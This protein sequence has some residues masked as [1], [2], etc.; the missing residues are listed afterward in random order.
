M[1]KK[2]FL[3]ES[4]RMMKAC[5]VALA[6]TAA[7][8]LAFGLVSVGGARRALLCA[9]GAFG[10]G[11]VLSYA[12]PLLL[13]A[14][15][16][17]KERYAYFRVA[18]VKDRDVCGGRLLTLF[19]SVTVFLA[20]E[21]LLVTLFDLLFFLGRQG[22]R[23]FVGQGMF[24]LSLR[25]HGAGRLLFSLSAAV[26]LCLVY[27]GYDLVRCAAKAPRTAGGKVCA[28]VAAAAAVCL[29]QGAALFFWQGSAFFDLNFIPAP[30]TFLPLLF[31][32]YRGFTDSVKDYHLLAA[33]ILNL[34]FLMTEAVFAAACI[35]FKKW[36]GRWRNEI[37][38]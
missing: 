8:L 19:F 11:I 32:S 15:T 34:L 20:A 28:A 30:D 2:V 29:L 13:L 31:G 5:G 22:L 25:A 9:E 16:F 10:A 35:F 38:A 27:Y 33:P 36:I 18:G 3:T 17:W 26:A 6:A 7:L 4:G 1:I 23:V 14:F 21:M 12:V 24:L 37:E